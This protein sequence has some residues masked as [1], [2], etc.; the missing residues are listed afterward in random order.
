[1]ALTGHATRQVFDRYNIVSG[2]DLAQ[3]ADLLQ[4]YLADNRQTPA[5]VSV[6]RTSAE[7][8]KSSA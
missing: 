1:M 4:A 3:A 7:L 5:K 2:A 6:L 8:A